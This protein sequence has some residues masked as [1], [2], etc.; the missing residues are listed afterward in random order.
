MT[1][2]NV[3]GL[4]QHGKDKDQ[5]KQD[6]T[7]Q[8]QRVD[9]TRLRYDKKRSNKE[10]DLGQRKKSKDNPKCTSFVFQEMN[11]SVVKNM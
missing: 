11:N 4:R 5:T 9:K 7:K 3:T 8:G 1:T 6:K 10:K 2:K